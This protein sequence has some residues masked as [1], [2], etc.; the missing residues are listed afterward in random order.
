MILLLISSSLSFQ[1]R[2]QLAES[3]EHLKGGGL[4]RTQTSSPAS[5]QP[6]ESWISGGSPVFVQEET[7]LSH[8]V[9]RLSPSEMTVGC[10][11]TFSVSQQHFSQ[12]HWKDF[13]GRNLA[14]EGGMTGL[15]SLVVLPLPP[16]VSCISQVI[17]KQFLPAI[18][19]PA[20][21]QLQVTLPLLC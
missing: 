11:V 10:F 3:P 12:K 4:K 6:S 9:F 16:S 14:F 18:W 13:W 15:G 20:T 21:L 17:E 7:N 5:E 2:W 1:E 19:G 8:V